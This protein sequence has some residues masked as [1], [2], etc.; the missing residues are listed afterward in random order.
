MQILL[1][2]SKRFHL[3]QTQIPMSAK[4]FYLLPSACL[5]R[6]VSKAPPIPFHFKLVNHIEPKEYAQHIAAKEIYNKM[7]PPALFEIVENIPKSILNEFKSKR[8]KYYYFRVPDNKCFDKPS[9]CMCKSKNVKKSKSNV[10]KWVLLLGCINSTICSIW[11]LL[12]IKVAQ[13]SIKVC[14]NYV[15]NT[16][17]ILRH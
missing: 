16:T 5:E 4:I 3:K 9:C 1:E 12:I 14:V 11:N 7:V 6:S 8:F 13:I 2:P 15:N 17:F 10:C